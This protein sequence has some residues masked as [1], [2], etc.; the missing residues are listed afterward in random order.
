[1]E[2]IATEIETFVFLQQLNSLKIAEQDFSLIE[3]CVSGFVTDLTQES[4]T[5][6]FRGFNFDSQSCPEG[7]HYSCFCHVAAAS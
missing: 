4:K 6:T 5:V 7:L 1:M 2:L 3:T